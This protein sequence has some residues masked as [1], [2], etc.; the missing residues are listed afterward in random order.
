[1][2]AFCQRQT[3]NTQ[4]TQLPA[5]NVRFLFDGERILDSQTPADVILNSH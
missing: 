5:H 2:D 3:V 1:M 4:L